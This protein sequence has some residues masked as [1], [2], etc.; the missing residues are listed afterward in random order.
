M[1]KATAASVCNTS[2]TNVFWAHKFSSLMGVAG[3]SEQWT[4]K[5]T[6]PTIRDLSQ[7]PITP[8]SAAADWRAVQALRAL[9]GVP[10]NK[11]AVLPERAH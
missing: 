9:H 1:A 3:N 11:F 5:F 4:I 6:V 8:D 2:G 7:P 10:N